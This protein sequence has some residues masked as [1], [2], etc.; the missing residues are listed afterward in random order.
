MVPAGTRPHNGP[1]VLAG[2][3]ESTTVAAFVTSPYGLM[4]PAEDPP[5][6]TENTCICFG[7]AAHSALVALVHSGR[8]PAEESWQLETFLTW[9]NTEF[10]RLSVD[11]HV[12]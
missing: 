8:D 6:P 11:T 9:I 12:C 10:T 3:W 4:L 1:S 5:P 7:R 2:Q